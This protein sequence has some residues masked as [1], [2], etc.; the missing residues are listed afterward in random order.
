MAPASEAP[1]WLRLERRALSN[2]CTTLDPD[3]LAAFIRLVNWAWANNGFV[4]EEIKPLC[5]IIGRDETFVAKFI[6]D[7]D[8]F[9][10]ETGFADGIVI[11]FVRDELANYAAM[12]EQKRNAGRLGGLRRHQGNTALRIVDGDADHA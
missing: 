3:E 12:V 1:E 8:G 2:W 6:A 4:P 5:R 10:I 9:F 11:P 7:W